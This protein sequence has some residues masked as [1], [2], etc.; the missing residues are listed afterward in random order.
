M[1]QVKAAS[2]AA[3]EG[4]ILM[5]FALEQ[6]RWNNNE[7]SAYDIARKIGMTPT[8]PRFR[9]ILSTMVKDGKLHAFECKT[10]STGVNNGVRFVYRVPQ[11]YEPKKR[12]IAIKSNGR[13]VGQLELF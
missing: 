4:M 12:E 8:S 6:Q 9:D 2:R 10:K 1:G 13:A 7:L 11:S 5:A 3:R